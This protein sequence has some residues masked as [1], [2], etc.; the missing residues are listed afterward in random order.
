MS[1]DY[2]N[3]PKLILENKGFSILASMTEA[4]D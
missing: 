1:R 4:T 3:E 2:I